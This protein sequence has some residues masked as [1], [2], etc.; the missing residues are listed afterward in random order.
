VTSKRK[1]LWKVVS[2]EDARTAARLGRKRR[3]LCA[4]SP[5]AF[6]VQRFKNFERWLQEDHS[7]SLSHRETEWCQTEIPSEAEEPD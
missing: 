3:D 5:K 2:I 6:N 4:L 1:T 7:L